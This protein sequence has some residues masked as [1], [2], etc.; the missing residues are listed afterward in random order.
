MTLTVEQKREIGRKVREENA[1]I[2]EAATCQDFG[3]VQIG[4]SRTKVDGKHPDG[5]NWS[6]KNAK[7]SST[8][9][10]LTSQE[11]FIA[12]FSLNAECQEFVAK[13]F[14]NLDYDHMPRRRYT[15]AEIDPVAVAHFKEFLE[16]NQKEVIYYFISG[17]HDINHL[18]YNGKHL[19]TEDVMLQAEEAQWVYNP[20]AIHLKNKEGKTLFH[21]QMKGSGKGKAKHGV[22]CHIHENL[23]HVA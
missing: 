16:S 10:H 4:G 2:K 8:Q 7:S 19:T 12:T 17:E 11:K 14:G 3:L 15:M 21:V 9:V 5:T 1:G 18:V 20:T 23:F 13:F 22:L 6:I